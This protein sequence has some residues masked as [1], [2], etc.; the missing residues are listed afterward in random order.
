MP[1]G[2]DA[3]SMKLD[4]QEA[5]GLFG[6]ELRLEIL[7]ALWE[8]PDFALP[9]TELRETVGERDSGKFTYH[10]SKLEDQFVRHVGDRYVLQYA[11][12]RIIDAVQSG[13]F[14]ESPEI[15][16]TELDGACPDCGT[17]PRFTYER[18]IATVSCSACDSKL[19]EYP[20]DPGG[21]RDRTIEEAADA[22]DRRTKYMWRLASGG[23][24]FVCAGRVTPSFTDSPPEFEYMDR[25]D[26]FF[27]ADHSAVVELTC[28]NCS[29]Y[30]YVPAGVRLLDHPAVVGRL[31]DGGI[32]LRERPLWSLPFITDAERVSVMRTDP[33]EVLVE[34]S[35]SGGTIEVRLDDD[36]AI[37]SVT[38][39]V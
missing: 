36:V 20:F 22:F 16:P 30:S 10:L 6:H 31:H 23:V 7:L 29:F 8:A 18:H 5:F 14:H 11:G 4:P 24:C 28:R 35:A 38:V 39:S 12:H 17:H 25:Y 34:T 13:V 32:D 33:W 9:F 27:A 15:A 3:A 26:A 21:F 37:Q 19:I 2:N 1:G